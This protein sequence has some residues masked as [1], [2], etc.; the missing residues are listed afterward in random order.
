M[1]DCSREIEDQRVLEKQLREIISD[2]DNLSSSEKSRGLCQSYLEEIDQIKKTFESNHEQLFDFV[3]DKS[4]PLSDV[5][6]F[7]EECHRKFNR[8]YLSGK[9]KFLDFISDFRDTFS[10]TFHSST[11]HALSHRNDSASCDVRLPKID[12]PTFSGDYLGWIS[13]RDMFI[14]LVHNNSSL[15]KVQKYYFLKNS[16]RDTPLSIVNEYPASEASYELAWAALGRRYHNK[17]KIADT[18]FRKL[19]DIPKSNG[20]CESIKMI[21]DNTRNCLALLNTLEISC[22][23]W[24]PILIHITVGKLDIQTCKEWEQSL[25]ASTDIPKLDELFIFLETAFRTLESISD[26]TGPSTR[27]QAKISKSNNRSFQTNN[28]YQVR[29]VNTVSVGDGN[30]PCCGKR[31]LLYKCFKFAALS[32]AAK[33]DL[34]KDKKIC[35]NCLNTGHFARECRIQSR[36]KTCNMNHHTI[37]HN[38]FSSNQ[39]ANNSVKFT[40]PVAT[41]SPDLDNPFPSFSDGTVATNSNVN[42]NLSLLNTTVMPQV[43][44][45]TVRVVVKTDFGVFKLRAILDQGAQATLITEQAAQLLKLRRY[46][47]FARIVG[48][49]GNQTITIRKYVKFCLSS[50]YETDFKLESSAFVMPSLTSY[51]AAPIDRKYLP[52]LSNLHLADP[53]FDR[54]DSIDLLLGG[55]IYGDIL[56]PQQKKFEKGIFLQLSHFGWVVSGPTS[57]ISYSPNLSI[58]FCSLDSQLK[59]FWEQEELSEPRKATPEEMVCEE[60]FVRNCTRSS[61]GRYTV[62]MPFKSQLAGQSAPTFAHSDYSA[63][64]RLK[65]VEN[66]FVREPRFASEYRKFMDEYESLGHMVKI[67]PYPQAIHSNGYFLPHHGVVRESSSTTK[68]RVVFDGSSRRLPQTSLNDELYPGPALQNDLPAIITRWRRFRIG[69]R[70]DLEKMFRQIRIVEDQQHYQQILWRSDSRIYVYRL[71]TV[72]YGTASAPYLSIRVLHQLAQDEVGKYPEACSILMSDTYVDD[73][74]SGADSESE[75]KYIQG[76]LVSL[77]AA[78]GFNLRKW[79]SNSRELMAH[80]PEDFRE[81]TDTLD[82]N[83]A[84]VVKALG[85]AWNTEQDSFSFHVNFESQ[86]EVTKCSLLSDASKL[87]DPLGWLAPVT[88]NAKIAFQKLWLE[89]IDWRDRVSAEMNAYWNR[90]ISDLKVLEQISIPRWVNCSLQSRLELH[91]FCDA[92]QSAFAAVVY[93]RVVGVN[94][95][96]SVFL[97]QSKTKV[98]PLKV[99]SIPKLEL[100]GARLLA[101]LMSKVRKSLEREILGVYYWTDSITVLCW[102]IGESSKWSVFVG[103]RVS[104]IQQHSN[105]SQWR[106]ISTKDNPADCAS[107]GITPS[108]LTVHDLWWSGPSWLSLPQTRWPKQPDNS[109]ETDLEIRKSS[110]TVNVASRSEYPD[111]LSKFSSLS[112]LTRVTAYILRFVH[113]SKVHDAHKRYTGFLKTTEINNAL[114][115]LILASQ[116]VD[117]FEDIVQLRK[118]ETVHSSSSIRILCPF[119]DEKGVIRVGGRLRKAKFHYDFKHPILLSK[120]NPLSCLIFADAHVK[121]LHGGLIQMQA[122]V[123]RKFWILSARNLAKLILRNCVTCFKYKAQSAQQIMGDLPAVRLQPCRPFKH[124]GV[125]YAGPITIKQSTARNSVPTKGY[126]CLFICMVTKAIHLEAVTTLSTD[127]FIAAFRRFTSRRGMC[128]E[129]YSDCGTNFI[130]ANKELQ[131]LHRRNRDSL[132]DELVDMLSTN[133]TNWHFIPPASPNFGGLWEAGVKSTKHHLKRI[134]SNRILTFEELTTLLAQIEGCLNSR[135]LCP[136]SSDPSDN[137]ALTPA[138]FLVGE[139]IL[140]VP[141][142]SLLDCSVDRLS[143]WKV[144]ELLKQQFW[145]RW[146]S[147][148]VNRLQS[149]PK[150]LKPQQNVEIGD[151]VLVFDERIPPGQWPLGRVTDVHPGADGRVRVVSLKSNGKVYKRPVSKIAVLPVKENFQ[152][153]EGQKKSCCES[154]HSQ[155]ISETE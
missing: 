126:I 129:L 120:H 152:L 119:I 127:S 108:E 31:H 37:V 78:G 29:R 63:L 103:N 42:C 22:D 141:H 6:Y 154:R 89:G 23:N 95:S 149:R 94:G 97:L 57:E 67:G 143:R 91:G 8:I 121:T 122:Y 33:F 135:P 54:G 27:T 142:E 106:Y 32:S 104:E 70:S 1:E 74:I 150:W 4:I 24:D 62:A 131:I 30:C 125:D 92:S 148:Y 77:L 88:I 7:S 76:Q 35:R 93:I 64:K 109:Y 3:R 45:A 81:R 21:L 56:L 96:G 11:F 16:C 111:I 155:V 72:T 71:Q 68:L 105:I 10:H 134:M 79:I 41:S 15:S 73:I 132:P 112:K 75:A 49:G 136:L 48:V 146:S 80:I 83:E 40:S 13:Y 138:H 133:G 28:S 100:C 50:S 5:P 147:E 69:F 85:L 66:R 118:G 59:A 58:N 140:N 14:S 113:N 52:D 117:F 51:H 55:D 90:Y 39:R 60:F 84:N 38:E 9:G 123:A 46:N 144:V 99:L 87:Y 86:C 53:D 130:G 107:R 116:P 43:L 17:R 153:T 101:R 102:L 65:Q 61:D 34:L 25:K 47:T 124:S 82:L 36:C 151:L 114:Q 18:V 19:F 115:A 145:K 110:I 2:F 137:E 98:A 139:P 128:S 20:S 44:L 26:H 12:I